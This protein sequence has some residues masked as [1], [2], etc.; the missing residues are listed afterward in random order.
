MWEVNLKGAYKEIN[1]IEKMPLKFVHEYTH[2][3]VDTHFENV[4]VRTI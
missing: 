4:A 1:N 2:M 3:Y